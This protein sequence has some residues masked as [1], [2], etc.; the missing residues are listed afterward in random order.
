MDLKTRSPFYIGGE[1]VPSCGP[2]T[3]G[4]LSGPWR[5]YGWII[6]ILPS[7]RP[8]PDMP[9]KHALQS[10]DGERDR[11]SEE[12]GSE[13]Q[14]RSCLTLILV[15][16]R[17]PS[18]PIH[19]L[20]RCVKIQSWYKWGRRREMDWKGEREGW[21]YRI[22]AMLSVETAKMDDQR[23]CES[24]S[25]ARESSVFSMRNRWVVTERNSLLF[26]LRSDNNLKHLSALSNW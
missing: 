7:T 24:R 5:A 15:I 10:Q 11:E 1:G 26:L 17:T 25:L 14:N 12:E 23:R 18:T 13:W 21:G 2:R 16:F 22:S 6:Q 4:S 19:S 8:R 20:R 9:I 3:P